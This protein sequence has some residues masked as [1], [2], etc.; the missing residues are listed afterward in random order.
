MHATGLEPAPQAVPRGHQSRRSSSGV[1]HGIGRGSMFGLSKG[2]RMII[3]V[4]GLIAFFAVHSVRIVAGGFRDRQAAGN[5]RR[6]KGIY[7]LVSLVGF[8]LIIW[9]WI[10]FRPEAP[11]I[12]EP[13]AWGRH[14]AWLLVAAAFV[15]LAAAYRPAGYIKY[16]VKHPM[17]TGVALWA[18]GHLLANGDLASLLVF[19]GFLVY[20]V[21]DRVAVIPRGDPAP[22]VK[23]PL[24][25]LVALVVGLVVFV[26]FGLWIHPFLFGVSPFP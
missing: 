7:S 22:E 1:L 4:I 21:V 5:V 3:L 24:S 26:A 17:L 13:P 18:I 8:A 25:D 9:G 23:Q 12:Y 10:V 20:A 2:A 14:V 19:G 6:W 11:Q 15:L 16:W